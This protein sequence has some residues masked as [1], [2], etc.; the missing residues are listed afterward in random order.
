MISDDE[1]MVLQR[2]YVAANKVAIEARREWDKV[3]TGD[4]E[5]TN[6]ASELHAAYVAVVAAEE[7]EATK[8][9]AL[10]AGLTGQ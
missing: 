10:F 7:V 3:T 2:E 1:K 8:R 5:Q 9:D 6:V 4:I